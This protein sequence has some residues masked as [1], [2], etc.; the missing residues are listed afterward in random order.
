MSHTLEKNSPCK[1]N[2]LLNILGKRPDGFHELETIMQPVNLC[3][4]LAFT[5]GGSGITLTC[6]E[7]TL[8]TDASNLVYRAA[9]AFLAQAKI[10]DGVAIHLEKQ[11][12]MAAG[13]GGGSGN[14]ATT[15]LALNELFGSPLTLAQLDAIAAS[16]GSDIP[17][18]LQDKPALAVGRGEKV[19]SLAPFAALRGTAFL[20]IHPG[21]GIATAWA[22]KELA[23]F[24]AALNGEPGR[25]EKLVALL[26]SA[27]LTVAGAAFYNSLEAPALDK[28]PLLALYQEFLRANGAAA[29]LMSGSGSTT[30]AIARSEADAQRLQELV[31]GKFGPCWTAVVPV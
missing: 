19:T 10:A 24:P 3:D 1:V 11:I 9:A 21:F 7:P 8:P 30:F 22:Y 23:R 6:T 20:L 4:R 15:L 25:A 26:N 31:K 14:A 17:F 18:F 2:L 29:A 12:P 13:L 5:R 16:L 27:D 28:Y